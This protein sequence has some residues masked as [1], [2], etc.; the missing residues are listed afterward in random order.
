[1]KAAGKGIS[2]CEPWRETTGNPVTYQG[3][4]WLKVKDGKIVEG[5]DFWNMGAVMQTLAG[6][7]AQA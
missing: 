7:P 4:T 2:R 1:M 3:M 5:R 6:G